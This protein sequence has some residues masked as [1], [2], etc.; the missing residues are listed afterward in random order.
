MKRPKIRDMTLIEEFRFRLLQRRRA[1]RRWLKRSATIDVS[2][3]NADERVELTQGVAHLKTVIAVT[4]P[5]W[6]A[7]ASLEEMTQVLRHLDPDS[8]RN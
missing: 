4:K 2:T 7:G 6:I 3:L 1:A 5:S 8:P